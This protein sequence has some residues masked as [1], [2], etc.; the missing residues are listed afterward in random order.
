MAKII[1]KETKPGKGISKNEPEKRRF[2]L[3]FELFFGKLGKLMQVNLIYTIA[4]TPL[5][6]GLFFSFDFNRAITSVADFS[7]MQIFTF[8]P[9]YISLIIL[10]VSI[11]I[12]GP[13][14]AGFVF[15]L[16][17]L[18]R[19][20]HTWIFSDFW[21]Q[22]KKNYWQGVCVGLID[23]IAYLALYIAFGFYMFVMPIDM[24]QMGSLMP[25][26]AGGIIV[27]I[28]LVFTWA[29]FYLY[30]MMVTFELKI[31]DLYKNALIFSL[32]KMPLNLFITAIIAILSVGALYLF[33]FSPEILA[34]VMGL[35][36]ISLIGFIIVFS[37]YP[38]I[39]KLMLKR[40]EEQHKRVLKY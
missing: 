28:T 5:L 7:K 29:H 17:N 1:T 35:I 26:I 27:A 4:L 18:Q 21:S 2:F 30:T 8:A 25:N 16:R 13:S 15:V 39:D 23:M 12:T 19:R 40:A 22:F 9:D 14:T 31:K 36:G 34:I 37:S 32:G 6:A 33:A 24:P 10:F 38:T 11:F 20:E 3:F